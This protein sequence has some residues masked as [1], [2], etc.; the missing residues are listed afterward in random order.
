[1]TKFLPALL[2][3]LVTAPAAADYTPFHERY[4]HQF[5]DEKPWDEGEITLPAYPDAGQG[6]WISLYVSPTYRNQA[7]VQLP[8]EVNQDGSV[9]YVLSIRAAGGQPNY[10]YEAFRCRDSLYKAFAFGDNSTQSWIP[11]R[12]SQWQNFDHYRAASDPVRARLM[13]IFCED[14]RP[15]DQQDAERRL[16]RQASR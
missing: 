13:R 8:L 7:Q 16:R 10:T 2:V 3:L 6:E 12:Q 9:R 1:M 14:G 4:G 11:S 15:S 5:E